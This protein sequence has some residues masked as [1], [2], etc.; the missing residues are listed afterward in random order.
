MEFTLG[1]IGT[2][3][4]ERTRGLWEFPVE[5]LGGPLSPAARCCPVCGDVQVTGRGRRDRHTPACTCDLEARA[6]GRRRV[7]RVR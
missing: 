3:C 6:R 7:R 2:A 5:V 1:R 4:G